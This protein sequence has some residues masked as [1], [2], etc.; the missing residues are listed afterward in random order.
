MS[1]VGGGRTEAGRVDSGL[2]ILGWNI[3]GGGERNFSNSL[4]LPQEEEGNEGL[5]SGS[6][7]IG[8]YMEGDDRKSSKSSS[9]LLFNL[10]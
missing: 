5:V 7:S 8:L 2:V 9:V 1:N 10:M 3:G 6:A 4:P